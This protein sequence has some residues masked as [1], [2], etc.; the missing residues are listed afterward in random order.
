MFL[1]NSGFETELISLIY[2][3]FVQTW[4]TAEYQ[5]LDLHKLKAQMSSKKSVHRPQN[6]L[7]TKLELRVN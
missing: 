2:S 5:R 4:K 7:W 1:T 6:S 3:R